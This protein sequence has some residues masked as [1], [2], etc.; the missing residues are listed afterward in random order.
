[1]RR[2]KTLI[3]CIGEVREAV[4]FFRYYAEQAKIY[5]ASANGLITC[6]S[7]WNFPLAIFSGQIAAALAA[8][9]TV[10]WQSLPR[11]PSMIAHFAAKL[12]H[13]AGVP[14]PSLQLVAGFGAE[15]GPTLCSHSKVTG[16]CFTGSMVHSAGH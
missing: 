16:V 14:E 4:D 12:M 15:I 11:V 9:V 8:G 13:Q 6:I 1:M 5:D 7:P 3:D 10:F 2:E